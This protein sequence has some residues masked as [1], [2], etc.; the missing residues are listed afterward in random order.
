MDRAS[1]IVEK[2]FANQ[3]Q[4]KDF[5][6]RHSFF[7]NGYKYYLAVIAASR[8]KEAQLTWSGLVESKVRL[9][10]TSL[11][12]VKSIEL[13]HPFVKGFDRVH[14]CQTEDEVERVAHGDLGFQTKGVETEAVNLVNGSKDDKTANKSSAGEPDARN[15]DADGQPK[16]APYTIYTTTFYIGIEI[17]QGSAR[18][19]G[20]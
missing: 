7:T 9:L 1:R 15:N 3:L 2:I 20:R 6:A 5:F 4:W 14:R 19:C 12:N 18:H 17:V 13:A 10:V 11:E 8:S 16:T